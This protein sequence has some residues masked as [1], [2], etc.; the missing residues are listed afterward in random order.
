MQVQSCVIPYT[1]KVIH[2][3]PMMVGVR[4][5]SSFTL[6]TFCVGLVC[7]SC[8]ELCVSGFRDMK[9]C[10]MHMICSADLHVSYIIQS[11]WYC[12]TNYT[13]VC[14]GSLAFA[15]ILDKPKLLSHCIP[16]VLTACTC[17][18]AP[19]H[20]SFVAQEACIRPI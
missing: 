11:S 15:G 20:G 13:T 17:H 7:C 1:S 9:R 5:K 3:L 2:V 6:E 18:C 14:S 8:S 16:N 10:S 12:S 4:R 19:E